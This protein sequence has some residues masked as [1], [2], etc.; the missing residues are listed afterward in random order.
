MVIQSWAARFNGPDSLNDVATALDV[1]GNIYVAEL[2]ADIEEN[3][4]ALVEWA[5][6]IR[7]GKKYIFW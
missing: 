2:M 3:R 1:N 5:N 7:V 4:K 6:K